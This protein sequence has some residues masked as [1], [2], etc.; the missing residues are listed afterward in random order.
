M[1]LSAQKLFEKRIPKI[2]KRLKPPKLKEPTRQ[3]FFLLLQSPG[4]QNYG[5]LSGVERGD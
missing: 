4:N 3:D 2:L 5:S 1:I